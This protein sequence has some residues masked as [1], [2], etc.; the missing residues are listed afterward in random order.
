VP[1]IEVSS[2]RSSGGG[3]STPTLIGE[4]EMRWKS[5]G[6]SLSGAGSGGTS[7]SQLGVG[8]PMTSNS[9]FLRFL[10]AP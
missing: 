2:L 3:C 9:Q 6:G 10:T 5:A 8:A 7:L 4:I 1:F